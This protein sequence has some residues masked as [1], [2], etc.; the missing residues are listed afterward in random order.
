MLYVSNNI[1]SKIFRFGKISLRGFTFSRLIAPRCCDFENIHFVKFAFQHLTVRYFSFWRNFVSKL[2]VTTIFRLTYLFFNEKL[3]A[4][5]LSF[6]N[7]YIRG[8]S[9]SKKICVGMHKWT[10]ITRCFFFFS[11]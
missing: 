5:V 10:I 7:I 9:H 11:I 3:F 2:W 4:T 6:L 8:F 1:I